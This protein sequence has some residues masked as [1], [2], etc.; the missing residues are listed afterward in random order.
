MIEIGARIVRGAFFKISE[1]FG[2]SRNLEYFRDGKSGLKIEQIGKLKPESR[3]AAIFGGG[4]R[5]RLWSLQAD[6]WATAS[7]ADLRFRLYLLL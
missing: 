7:F 2:E 5:L 1:R 3:L 6:L 4:T